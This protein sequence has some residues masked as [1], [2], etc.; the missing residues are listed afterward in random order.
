M[1]A[2]GRHYALT[3]PDLAPWRERLA[4]HGIESVEED[5]GRQAS[6]FIR[7]PEGTMWEITS[8][9]SAG[10]LK[11]GDHPAAVVKAYL[12]GRARTSQA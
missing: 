8:P 10:A 2:D 5:H 9:G 12:A 4:A 7:A 3:T 6:L 1:P 11:A